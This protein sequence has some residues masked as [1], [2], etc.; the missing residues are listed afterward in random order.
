MGSHIVYVWS[1]REIK[2][3]NK[4]HIY[5]WLKNRFFNHMYIYGFYFTCASYVNNVGSHI[6]RALRFLFYFKL[7]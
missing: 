6:V 5:M 1:T 4:K 2:T 7:A 3:Y